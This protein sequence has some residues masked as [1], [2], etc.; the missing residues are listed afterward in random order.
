MYT[1][2]YRH[3]ATRLY[4]VFHSLRRTAIIMQVSHSSVARWIADPYRTRA[5]KTH[6]AHKTQIVATS[7]RCT[8]Q[9]NPFFSVRDIRHIVFKATHVC[10]SASLVCS[11]I[12][13]LGL[14]KKKA[15]FHA[16]PPYVQER[17][18]D[19]LRVRDELRRN[20]VPLVAVDETSFGRNG[21]AVHGY[22]QK[23]C[24]LFVANRPA[25]MTT[26]SVL[27]AMQEDGTFMYTRRVGPFNASSFV[28]HMRQ[29]PLRRG[30]AVL[31][32]NVAFHHSSIVHEY[33]RNRGVMLV[34][35]PPYS[36]WFNPIE[37]AFSIAKRHFYAYRDLEA[38]L[39]AVTSRHV[40]AFFRKS[41]SLRSDLGQKVCI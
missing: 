34:Y 36:P 37:G 31:L 19:F 9:V 5:H 18:L 17:I 13:A 26:T 35:V 32:D 40:R 1:P 3:I 24:P 41:L 2:D 20:N 39:Q 12:N 33:A 22:S 14:S 23:G 4:E 25:R 8:V 16:R 29:F 15:R 27:A 30:T 6:T 38:G 7:V 21:P 10:V 11:V 28:D